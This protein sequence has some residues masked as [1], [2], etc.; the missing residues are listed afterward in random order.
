MPLICFASPKGGVGKTTLAANVGAELTRAGHRVTLLDLDPQ[1][2]LRL[3]F[4]VPLA[5]GGGVMPLLAAGADWRAAAR[6]TA[7]GATLLPFGMMDM[8]G[9][10]AFAAR[11][12]ADP[13]PLAGMLAALLADPAAVLLVDSAP[14]PSPALSAVL[15]ATSQLVAV[16]LADA[17]STVLIPPVEN[18]QAFGALPAG[19]IGFVLNQVDP[20]RRLARLAEEAARRHLGPRLLGTIHRDETVA[21]AV[22]ASRLLQDAAP[23]GVATRE[24]AALARTLAARLPQPLAPTAPH[25]SPTAAPMTSPKT[26]PVPPAPNA[27]PPSPETA[28]RGRWRWWR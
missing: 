1:N 9:A 26:T 11:L 6:R 13:S 16:L 14:G 22:G 4:G 24:I 23:S 12:A 27:A 2:A 8:A 21:E 20:R 15:P 18:G 7:C 5:D 19:R 28:R 10:V 3:H 17:T 25:P